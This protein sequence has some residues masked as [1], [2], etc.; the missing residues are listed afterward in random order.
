MNFEAL[1]PEFDRHWPILEEAVL[2]YGPTHGKEHVW[3]DI[4]AL[5]AQFWTMP[6]SAI[7][8]KILTH[9]TGFKEL[10]WWLAAGDLDEIKAIEPLILGW[11]HQNGC[12]RASATWR[13][14]W[15]KA[16][17]GYRNVAVTA[18]KDLPHG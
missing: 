11:A 4:E 13:A 10:W 1:R 2:R 16:M 15:T 12:M 5:R 6:N 3:A 17:D 9:P 18:I 8:S 7:V 14:G